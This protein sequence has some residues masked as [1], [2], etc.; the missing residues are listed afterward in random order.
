MDGNAYLTAGITVPIYIA[1][2]NVIGVDQKGEI[3]FKFSLSNC[4]L[5]ILSFLFALF[6]DLLFNLIT[7]FIIRPSVSEGVRVVLNLQ[8]YAA[9]ILLIGFQALA[10]YLCLPA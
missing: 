1:A 7:N 5:P 3:I 9:V 10:A 8:R 6:F 2:C 4:Y